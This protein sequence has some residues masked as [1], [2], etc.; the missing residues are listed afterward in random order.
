LFLN[1]SNVIFGIDG[2]YVL[3]VK[4]WKE[5]KMKRPSKY[6]KPEPPLTTGDIARYCHTSATQVNRWIKRG[7]LNSF[8]TPGGQ[9]RV[10]RNEF[11]SFLQKHKM[12][13]EGEYFG[14]QL[15]KKILVV[16]DDQAL[17]DVIFALLKAQP[18]DYLLEK[19]NNGYEA[20]LIAGDFKP[21]LIILD[22]RMPRIDGLEVCRQLKK[23]KKT[24][25]RI[26]IIV[27]TGHANADQ[28]QEV[29]TTGADDYL[30][31]PF[32]MQALLNRVRALVG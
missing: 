26:K 3:F 24:A 17:V 22:I 5:V 30:L 9:N 16:D 27:I 13:L 1:V 28:R 2:K 7:V 15:A 10:T 19:A 25:Y 32:E 29:L 4:N 8:K 6:S 14:E 11:K 20:L 31:K 12:P 21:D 18:E 23:S